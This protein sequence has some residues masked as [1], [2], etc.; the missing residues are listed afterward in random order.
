MQVKPSLAIAAISAAL[1]AKLVPMLQGSPGTGK[2]DIIRN[3]ASTFNLKVIDVRLSQCDPTDLN[4]LPSTSNNRARYLPM[5]TFPIEGDPLPEGYSGWLLFLDEMNSAPVAVQAAAYKIILD[6][7][8]GQH[9]LH[10]NVAIVGAGNLE[11]DGAIVE[12]MS[13]AMQSRLVHL[14]LVVDHKEWIDWASSACLDHRITSYVKFK[15]GQ[16]H[17]FQPD[18]SDK[19]Y[20]CPRTWEFANRILK[21]SEIG[22][23]TTLPLLAGTLSE[24]V[25]REFIVFCKIFDSLPKMVDII[26]D[27]KGVPVPD[28]P[29]VLFALT[30]AISHNATQETITPLIDFVERMPAE[31][32]IVCMR[33]VV[34]RNKAMASQTAVQKWIIKSAADLF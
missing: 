26:R 12:P 18:H 27:P 6:H 5:D 19:T 28:A 21:F 13:T 15:P 4:G 25:A 23:A 31:F 29:S 24:G 34:R 10:S 9:N 7:A 20:A 2:S 33:E 11:T 14:E 16:L 3:I 17:T 32:Q 30:G 22:E 1:Q 8:V